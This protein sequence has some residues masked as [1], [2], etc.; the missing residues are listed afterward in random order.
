MK[1]SGRDISLLLFLFVLAAFFRIYSYIFLRDFPLYKCPFPSSDVDFYMA[2]AVFMHQ[3]IPFVNGQ[4]FYYSPLYGLFY[5]I[6]SYITDNYLPILTVL[7]IILGSTT[8]AGVYLILRKL[9]L[10]R[11]ISFAGGVTFSLYDVAVIYDIFPLKTTTGIFLIVW[12]LFFLISWYIDRK[13]V[14]LVVSGILFGFTS[15]VYV[16]LLMF[17]SVIAIYLGLKKL[18]YGVLFTIP[19]FITVGFTAFLNYMKTSEFIPVTAIGGI[20]FYIGNNQQANGT[21]TYI[22]GIRPSGFGHY[23]DS[24]V[25]AE[26]LSGE[27]MTPGKASSFWRKQAFRFIINNPGDFVKLTMTKL[28]LFFNYFDIPNN[29]NKN[30]LEDR[31]PFLK[32]MTVHS[33]ILLVFGISSFMFLIKER[34]L[35]ILHIFLITCVLSVILFFVTDR[36]R[37]PAFIPLVIYIF[38][39][40]SKIPGWSKEKKLLFLATVLS[41]G[42]IVFHET[43]I[44]RDDYDRISVKRLAVSADICKIRENSRMPDR[45]YMLRLGY[46]YLHTGSYEQAYYYLEKAGTDNKKTENVLNYLRSKLKWYFSDMSE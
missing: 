40:S 37:L 29:I 8:G 5:Y 11:L 31:I 33:G 18:R 44:S 4:P 35:E 34:K 12:G 38:F 36:Y 39:L 19:V 10:N 24:I 46:I 21:Y 16:N 6:A 7:N 22:P 1:Q 20:H 25:V 13:S 43:G 41:A 9:N 3:D 28:M 27:K 32:H 23:H 2:L 15:L 14:S 26:E 30:F 42:F 17:I 45:E